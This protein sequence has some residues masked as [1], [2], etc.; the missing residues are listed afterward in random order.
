[1]ESQIERVLGSRKQKTALSG[2]RRVSDIQRG[3]WEQQ[4]RGQGD[5]REGKQSHL[6]TWIALELEERKKKVNWGLW[7]FLL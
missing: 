3:V 2:E 6:W 4:Q 5:H 1:M 7:A